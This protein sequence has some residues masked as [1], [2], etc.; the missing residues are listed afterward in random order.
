MAVLQFNKAVVREERKVL[1]NGDLFEFDPS[2]TATNILPKSREPQHGS[3][4]IV[5]PA[6]KEPIN[7]AHDYR[8]LIPG[9]SLAGSIP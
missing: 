8:F 2:M 7:I 6:W 4:F 1:P 9:R 5:V 3:D